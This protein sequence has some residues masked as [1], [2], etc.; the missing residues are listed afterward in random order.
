[1]SKQKATRKEK[2]S[3]QPALKSIE[4]L[5]K[6]KY[7]SAERWLGLIII[8]VGFL[9][10][11]NTL[12]HGYALDDYSSII[13]NKTTQKGFNG[14]G[15]IFKTSYR[16]GYIFI[17]D[18]L[19]RPIAKSLLAVEWG[20]APN[21]PSLAH[22]TNV[23]LFMLTGWLLFK[24]LFDWL[25]GNLFVAFAT[26]LLFITLPIHTE[27]VANIKSVDEILGLLFG[28]LMLRSI[29]KF[30]LSGNI[31]SL[32][33]GAFWFLIAMFSKESSI[34]LLAVV[35]LISYFFSG[36]SIKS[37]LIP[38]GIC[39]IIAFVFLGIRSKVLGPVGISIKPSIID[40]ML[41]GAP[42]VLTRIS[43]SVY[44]LGL[45]LKT[46]LVPSILT[47]DNSYPQ[48]PMVGIG[49][50]R[51]ILSAV[52]LVSLLVLAIVG[53]K[54]K[55]IYSFAILFFFVT[56]SVSSNLF[57]T[58][59]THY[60][61]RLMYTPSLGVCLMFAAILFR[62]IP[63]KDEKL[64]F[65]NSNKL[66]LAILLVVS[67]TYGGLAIARN[68]VWK[69][70]VSLYVSGLSSS[71]N[72]TRVQ[73]YM[74]NLLVK[75]EQLAG[76]SRV[77]QDS[78]L[79]TGIGFLKAAIKLTPSFTDAWNQMGIAYDRL[80]NPEQAIRC[81]LE[82]LKYN[83]NDPTIHNNLGTVYFRANKYKD[84][85]DQ[86]LEAVRLNPRYAEAWM[87]V[88]SCYGATQ[89]LD[90]AIPNFEKA[91]EVD[92]KMANAYYFLGVTWQSKGNALI[93]NQYLEQAYTLNPSLR[94]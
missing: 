88:G 54:K 47:F 66:G 51:F 6:Q 35:P 63:N 29:H 84:A 42:N 80:K 8:L 89:Q 9:V 12:N 55:E 64:N 15:E 77:Q 32:F 71:P 19:Y 83:P 13:E 33:S 78:I 60:G 30:N 24:T 4:N 76:K 91:I 57:V 70:N 79:N 39:L 36:K 61:E 31:F 59:G 18:E 23:L 43:T 21:K 68:P 37:S 82:G 53:W 25:N 74:G 81:Y 85:I 94:K 41:M 46:I 48:L 10:Y 45:Y 3:A 17:N 49:A 72:S 92:P 58:I 38:T 69:N 26:S 52:V 67:L 28:L 11:A 50:W 93:A 65:L 56:V 16:Y 20:I 7:L 62:F 44:L 87:N 22:W 40:N 2:F 73:Y 86:F 34:T 5:A 27:T 75:E 1:M 90:S 14:I